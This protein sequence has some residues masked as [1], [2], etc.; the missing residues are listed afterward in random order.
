[1]DISLQKL[2]A[3]MEEQIK[4]A[5]AASSASEMREKIHT[6][7]TLC[8]LVLDEPKAGPAPEPKISMIQ[9]G[10]VPATLQQPKRLEA[11]GGANGESLFD[12]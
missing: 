10:P 11:K 1:M 8:E 9:Q 4:G 3:K 12:F 2:L 5:R 7:Q 6:I